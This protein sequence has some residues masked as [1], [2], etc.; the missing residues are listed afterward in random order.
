MSEQSTTS[1]SL[2]EIDNALELL[3]QERALVLKNE[4][5]Q[6]LVQVKQIVAKYGFTAEQLFGETKIRAQAV[7][8]YKDPETG[9][10]WSGRGREPKWIKGKNH[11]QFLIQ[12]SDRS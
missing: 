2:E 11:D 12:D 9:L 8:K 7:A 4:S 1:R 6:A 3:H 5:K 10:T